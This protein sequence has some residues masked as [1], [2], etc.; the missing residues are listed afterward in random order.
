MD[1]N[2]EPYPIFK[3]S[4]SR[5]FHGILDIEHYKQ[6]HKDNFLNYL[7]THGKMTDN[8]HLDIFINVKNK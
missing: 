2:M 8:Q 5:I 4:N 3:F 6:E 1:E 7:M